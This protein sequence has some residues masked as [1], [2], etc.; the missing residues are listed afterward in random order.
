MRH[1][2]DTRMRPWAFCVDLGKF[3]N[4]LLVSWAVKEACVSSEECR[5][6]AGTWHG[7]SVCVLLHVGLLCARA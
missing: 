7:A 3:P 6:L 4:V 2:T 5:C 1:Y